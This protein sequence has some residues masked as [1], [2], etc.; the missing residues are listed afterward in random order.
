MANILKGLQPERVFAHFEAL[1][2][3][4]RGS[5][6]EKQVSDYLLNTF[7][8]KGFETVQDEH[9]NIIIKKPA[10][11]GYEHAPTV[12][13][14][15]H[16]DMVCEKNADVEHDFLSDPIKLRVVGD[17]IYATGTT[18][19]ADN[20]IGVA[21]ALAV[22]EDE[23]LRHPALEVVITTDEERGMVGATRLDC[24]SLK[25]KVLLNL[26]NGGEGVFTAGC[27]GGGRVIYTVPVRKA[28]R[29]KR[30]GFHLT[31]RGLTG[32]HSGADIHLGRGNAI[33]IM[34]RVL[35]GL[36]EL[37]EL[38]AVSGGSKENAIPREADAT[39]CCDDRQALEQEIRKWDALLKEEYAVADAGISLQLEEC[40]PPERVFDAAT[41]A[42]I[43]S[44]ILLIPNGVN[45]QDGDIGLV[46][47]SNNLGVVEQTEGA[48]ILKSCPRSSLDSSMYRDLLYQMKAV[49][50]ALEIGFDAVEFYPGWKY[51]K[52]SSIRDLCVATYEELNGRKATVSAIHAGL[53]CGFLISKLPGLDAV[54]FGPVMFGAHTPEESLDIP[55]VGRVY[56]LIAR[57]LKQMD[58]I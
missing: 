52:Q 38:S 33:K 47:S 5:G 51:E 45:T 53:E 36:G 49:A 39:L 7:R 16:M 44:A 26:D 8:A 11:K 55:S 48:V 32:G 12:M 46:I 1:S 23:S 43:I 28:Q 21:L 41:K 2:E 58:N 57:I 25:S 17:R 29:S 24:S 14:Q 15:G 35:Y 31:V 6:N 10:S 4:P 13:L 20:G 42:K 50:E 30:Q 3:I 56:Q 19:G 9:W 34:G 37:V 54:A 40:F 27:A 18:L 22:L